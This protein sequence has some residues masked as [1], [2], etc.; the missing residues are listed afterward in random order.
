[1]RGNL[2]DLIPDT[3][4]FLSMPPARL[5]GFFLLDCLKFSAQDKP[6]RFLPSELADHVSRN[7]LNT[8]E[9]MAAT[10]EALAWLIS[11]ALVVPDYQVCHAGSSYLRLS[12]AGLAVNSQQDVDALIW[13][14]QN[15]PKSLLHPLV[16]QHAI[17][18]FLTGSYDTAI[19]E[20][21]KQVE[22]ALK[23]ATGLHNFFGVDLARKAFA[24]T[25]GPLSDGA[26]Q[27][28]EQQATSDLFAGAMGSFR[29][30]PGHRNLDIK[31][32]EAAEILIF[33]SHLLG[34][35]NARVEQ[36]AA[37]STAVIGTP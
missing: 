32:K 1:M 24:V 28:S 22:I 31:P 17:P 20:A 29:N 35:I 23:D 11:E 3:N 21:F 18:I 36:I 9:A 5:A 34:I 30:P 7:Y 8:E 13:I 33:A 12:K 6:G 27:N 25:T 14:R 15:L 19:F 37:A 16:T 10:M 4:E 2:K 26:L